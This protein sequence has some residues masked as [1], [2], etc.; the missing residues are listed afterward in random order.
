MKTVINKFSVFVL[1]A[2]LVV[3][4]FPSYVASADSTVLKD[5]G[6]Y[7]VNVNFF[8]DKTGSTT[9]EK[10]V[11]DDYINNEATIK[12]ENNQPYLYLNVKNSSWWKAMAVSETGNRPETPN[13]KEDYAGK[14]NDVQIVS[15]DDSTQTQVIK[16]KV[17]DLN[18]IVYSYMHIVVDTIPGFTYDNW[19]QIDLVIDPAS[20]Q[21]ISE[22]EEKPAALADGT[23]KVPF[24]A[25]HATEDKASSMQK[26]FD[27]PVY[28]QVKDGKRTAA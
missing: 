1:I 14:Y 11:A 25:K 27:N 9:K 16:I 3:S 17:E 22:P 21:V 23:Y 5:G 20:V 2:M 15:K 18:K 4:F 12:V 24:A 26:Y 10:S 6:E 28:I 7:K 13:P 8:K 19:Y